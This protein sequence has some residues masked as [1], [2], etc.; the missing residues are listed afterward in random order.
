[1]Q[2]IALLQF[3]TF[4]KLHHHSD[5]VMM[6]DMKRNELFSHDLRTVVIIELYRIRIVQ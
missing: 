4:F 5:D 6:T 1:M 3:V 2:S